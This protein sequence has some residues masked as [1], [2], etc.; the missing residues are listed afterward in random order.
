MRTLQTNQS[1]RQ[2]HQKILSQGAMPKEFQLGSERS[3]REPEIEIGTIIAITETALIIDEPIATVERDRQHHEARTE[4][5]IG[6][7]R[8]S[9]EQSKAA[10]SFQ[11]EQC[12]RCG[13]Q[14]CASKECRNCFECW[15]PNHFKRNCPHLNENLLQMAEFHFQLAI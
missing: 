12:R 5:E 2:G 4:A 14:N 1:N 3:S 7:T 10:V 9:V 15:S 6:K 11:R 8:V 13:Q